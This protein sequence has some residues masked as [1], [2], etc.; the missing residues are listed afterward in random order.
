[1]LFYEVVG[2]STKKFV[3]PDRKKITCGVIT[4]L[5]DKQSGKKIYIEDFIN[6]FGAR[7]PKAETYLYPTSFQTTDDN[8]D[9]VR[10]DDF[11]VIQK[12]LFG[13]FKSYKKESLGSFKV[14]QETE[15]G[16]LYTFAHP[17]ITVVCDYST[18][19]SEGWATKK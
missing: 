10:L 8:P 4:T 5:A 14:K 6:N 13:R 19:V 3:L 7:L 17:N 9:I 11:I 15:F 18:A 12:K 16:G 1:M 2:A